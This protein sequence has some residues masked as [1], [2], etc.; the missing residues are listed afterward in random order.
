MSIVDDPL[1]DGM[2]DMFKQEQDDREDGCSDCHDKVNYDCPCFTEGF[3][4]AEA[5]RGFNSVQEER[6]RT[7]AAVTALETFKGNWTEKD[8]IK[9]SDV[10]EILKGAEHE[11][12][13]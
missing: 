10:L 4:V 6:E 5:E 7:V 2:M 12:T 11:R 13:K 8:F 3:L 9:K 1:Y